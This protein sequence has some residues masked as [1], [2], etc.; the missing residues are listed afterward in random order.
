LPVP[1]PFAFAVLACLL[2]AAPA[3]AQSEWAAPQLKEMD[4]VFGQPVEGLTFEGS[5]P[6]GQIGTV[7][8]TLPAAGRY[9]FVGACGGDCADIGLILDHDGKS[10][11]EGVTG[12]K[13][14]LAA[15]EY[16]L[17]VGFDQCK[18]TQCRYVVR[19]YKAG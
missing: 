9:A 7:K 8:V 16:E 1:K 11:A 13:Q 6:A 18:E 2:V 17:K 19:V 15:G 10:V 5:A 3:L 4:A 12:F 14:T